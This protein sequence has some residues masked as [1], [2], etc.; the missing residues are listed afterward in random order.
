MGS[1]AVERGRCDLQAICRIGMF[2]PK[3]DDRRFAD[4]S[5][6]ALMVPR[7]DGVFVILVDPIPKSGAMIA[8]DVG[9]HRNRFRIAHEIG[10]SF[11]YDRSKK[12]SK[13][14]R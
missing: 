13:A 6:D 1:S 8:P 3:R 4:S 7:R 11:F 10:H 2:L 12:A 5:H 9:R 14:T